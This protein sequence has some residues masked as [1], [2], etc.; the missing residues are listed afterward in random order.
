MN[1]ILLLNVTGQDR[2]GMTNAITTTMAQY[3]VVILDIGQAVIHDTLTW[4]ILIRL[5][6]TSSSAP[7]LKELLYQLHQMELQVKYQPVTADSYQEWVDEQG[8]DQY[9]VT[10]LARCLTAEQIARVSGLT[11]QHGLNIDNITRLTG[12]VPL[13]SVDEG[14]RAVVEFAVRGTPIDLE[15]LRTDFLHI[16]SELDV[17]IAFQHDTVFR[18]N[19]RLVVFDMDSTLIEAEVIDELAKAAGVGAQVIAITE[20]AMRGELEFA[21]SF[22]RRMALL[23]GLDEG[24]LSAI[25]EKLPLTEGAERLIRNLK[26]LGYQTAI[27]SGG[28]TW[29][30]RYLQQKLGVDYIYANEL[31][32]VDGKVTGNVTGPIVDGQRK[33]KLMHE[34]ASKHQISLEQVIAVGDGAND[35]PMLSQAGLGIAFRAKPLVRQNARHAISM[36]G[37]D[38]VLY[39][40]GYRDRD[41]TALD[42]L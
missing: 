30:A 4:G 6:E 5:S 38:A 25:A 41:I 3:D 16:S 39:L 7:V 23:Q 28:F 8:K 22:R 24:V 14:G 2:P 11:A 33:A 12:R 17:D 31:E 34:I 40:M 42:Q 13:S 19:R 20:A 1:E 36:L 9:I 21:E 37:L 18:R 35:L 26:K 10:L 29:F 32:I 27:L 15:A